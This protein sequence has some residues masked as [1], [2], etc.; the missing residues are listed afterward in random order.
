MASDAQRGRRDSWRGLV[1]T[2]LDRNPGSERRGRL[3]LG[4]VQVWSRTMPKGIQCITSTRCAPSRIRCEDGTSG[5]SGR[6]CTGDRHSIGWKGWRICRRIVGYQ[7][8][9]PS[10]A[11]SFGGSVFTVP[12]A[13]LKPRP[14]LRVL[15]AGGEGCIH[16]YVS[17]ISRSSQPDVKQESDVA[18]GFLS[19]VLFWTSVSRCKASIPNSPTLATLLPLLQQ[20]ARVAQSPVSKSVSGLR[21]LLSCFFFS[22][23]CK[24]VSAAKRE[25]DRRAV[26]C[27]RLASAR[28]MPTGLLVIRC[29]AARLLVVVEH[30]RGQ[31]CDP[32]R[33]DD[34]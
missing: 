12:T 29:W 26:W 22:F 17:Y 5:S 7:S 28:P 14:A 31:S 2:M 10:T 25:L 33:C 23:S 18:Q 8:P 24:V 11:Q 16:S 19:S 20:V 30:K 1:G 9:Q 4:Q 34:G 15:G 27:A 6:R 32:R 3:A 13:S 21:Y